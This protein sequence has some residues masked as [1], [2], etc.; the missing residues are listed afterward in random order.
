MGSP[1]SAKA[2]AAV[3][4][5]IER[6]GPGASRLPVTELVL[7][8]RDVDRPLEIDLASARRIGVPVVVLRETEGRQ[9]YAGG[10]LDQ[11]T[12]REREIAAL[13]SK[14]GRNREIARTLHI[15]EATVKDHVHHILVKL[16]MT[17]RTELAALL[18]RR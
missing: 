17:S 13:V 12:K 16:G 8:A 3:R 2:A 4:R 10:Q 11:L 14:G 5:A 9:T 15:S 1:L 18:A 7:L 6:I